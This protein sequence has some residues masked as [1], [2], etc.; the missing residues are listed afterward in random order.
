MKSL[1]DSNIA[2]KSPLCYCSRQRQPERNSYT[3]QYRLSNSVG[4]PV[5]ADE[6]YNLRSPIHPVAVSRTQ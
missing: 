6:Q 2:R 1:V 4:S 3:R 5:R